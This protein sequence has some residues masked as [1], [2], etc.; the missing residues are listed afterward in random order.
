[1]SWCLSGCILAVTGCV[2]AAGRQSLSRTTAGFTFCPAAAA[3]AA[4]PEPAVFCPVVPRAT[5]DVR[6]HVTQ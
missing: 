2:D 4:A 3:A 1:M 6:G 5:V